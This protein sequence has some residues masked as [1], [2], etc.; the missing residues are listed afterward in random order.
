[1]SA[2]YQHEVV[3]SPDAAKPFTAILRVNGKV[4]LSW[5]VSTREEGDALLRDTERRLRSFQWEIR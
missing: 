5:P 3:L 4:I 2:T 1:M